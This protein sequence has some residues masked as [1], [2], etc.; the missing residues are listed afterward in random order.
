MQGRIAIVTGGGQGLGRAFARGLAAEGATVVI[1]EINAQN[2]EKVAA[3]ITGDG[4][5]ALA[6]ATD[7]GN[8]EDVNATIAQV[9]AEFGRIDILVN[10]AASLSQ[11]RRAPV[12][13][14][15]DDEWAK[16]I[17]TNLTGAFYCVRAVVPHM[18]KAKWGR[19]INLSS[20]TA[21]F[22]PIG[23]TFTH[24]ISS[25]AALVGLTRSLARELGPDGITVNAIMPG[26]T[27][28][29]VDRGEERQ[30]HLEKNVLPLQ[31]IPRAEVPDDLVDAVK[32]L[33][34][35]AA[36]FITGQCLPVNG[37]IAFI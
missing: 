36:S 10:N 28:T 11:M 7:V 19:N 29:E 30:T 2:G 16:V 27:A 26:A 15:T 17:Q 5:Q 21:I 32:F 14:L 23:A 4:G 33:A 35:D 37:G 18:R 20:D 6:I 13:E 34:S 22:P 1:A 3:E 31:S 9:R 8:S 12:D 24:Y 25:K